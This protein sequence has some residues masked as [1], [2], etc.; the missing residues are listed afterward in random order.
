MAV[1]DHAIASLNTWIEISYEDLK[2]EWVSNQYEKLSDCPSFKDTAAY[3]EAMNVLTN[4]SNFPERIEDQL[5]KSLDEEL[6]L[7]RFWKDSK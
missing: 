2:K 6:E 7:E 3:R 5:R 1:D 4:G